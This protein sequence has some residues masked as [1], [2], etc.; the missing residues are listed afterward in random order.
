MGIYDTV[1]FN[2]IFTDDL[3]FGRRDC[4]QEERKRGKPEP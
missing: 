4:L 3:D 2:R 1:D